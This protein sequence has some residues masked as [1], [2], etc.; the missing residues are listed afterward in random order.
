MSTTAGRLSSQR[1]GP[2]LA[3]RAPAELAAA[4]HEAHACGA[5]PRHA[6]VPFH[7]GIE[8]EDVAVAIDG[9]VVGVAGADVDQLPL[10]AVE[11]RL[12]Q[13][14]AGGELVAHEATAEQHREK[15]VLGPIDAARGS[16]RSW[17]PVWLPHIT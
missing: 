4:L 1:T 8:A 14:A 3:A 9:D 7:V 13:P 12:R 2:F 16:F 17:V 6:G 5:I 15:L 11:I 10:F